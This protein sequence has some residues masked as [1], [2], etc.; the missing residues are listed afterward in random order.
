MASNRLQFTPNL[1]CG[2]ESLYLDMM[3]SICKICLSL[4]FV[5]NRKVVEGS[6]EVHGQVKKWNA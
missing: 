2:A 5:D 4:T 3:L 1:G 6:T